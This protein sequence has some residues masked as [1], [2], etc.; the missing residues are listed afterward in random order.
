MIKL[1][2]VMG[3]GTVAVVFEGP[4]LEGN[5]RG[6]ESSDCSHDCLASLKRI[7][8]P[9]LS[10]RYIEIV[11]VEKEQLSFLLGRYWG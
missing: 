7:L 9:F 3:P 6:R 4:S 11:S 8:Q 5:G 1:F 2:R 10:E